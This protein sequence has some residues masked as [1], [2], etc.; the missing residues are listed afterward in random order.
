[1]FVNQHGKKLSTVI[2]NRDLDSII[3]KTQITKHIS[4]HRLRDSFATI[5]YI[6]GSD[7]KSIQETLGH[8]TIQMTLHYVQKVDERRKEQIIG[9]GV[10][11]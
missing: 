5:Q 2:I 3:G 9:S 4:A 10:Q 7:I 6:N 8:E 11:F 1:M